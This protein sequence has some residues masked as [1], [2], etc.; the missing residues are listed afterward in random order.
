VAKECQWDGE[1][2][3]CEP[4]KGERYC[5]AHRKA[6]LK[7]MEECGYLQPLPQPPQFIKRG[8]NEDE[9]VDG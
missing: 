4:V 1:K 8:S 6:M 7:R 9:D 5:P 2:C 3:A